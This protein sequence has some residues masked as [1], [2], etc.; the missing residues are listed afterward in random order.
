MTD[1]STIARP[2]TELSVTERYEILLQDLT[3]IRVET[4]YRMRRELME[5]RYAMGEA[6]VS[7][8]WYKRSVPGQSRRFIVQVARDLE[9]SSR[10]VYYCVKAF[11]EISDQG[12]LDAWLD[13]NGAG[14][15]VSWSWVKQKLEAGEKDEVVETLPEHQSDH[16]MSLGFRGNRKAAVT[17]ARKKVGTLWTE[18]DQAQM[19]QILAVKDK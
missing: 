14:K 3:A 5:A 13:A 17:Y 11:N 4:S 10:E 12:G 16:N 7:G 19:E 18:E 2:T 9:M 6:I 8:G 1:L 15:N